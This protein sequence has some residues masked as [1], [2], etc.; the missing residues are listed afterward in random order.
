MKTMIMS[1]LVM[2][3]V[4]TSPKEIKGKVSNKVNYENIEGAKVVVNSKDTVYTDSKGYFLLENVDTLKRIDVFY[5]N[6]RP[7]DF[8]L[9]RVNQD[10]IDLYI[11]K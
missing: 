11:K 6:N 4:G 3:C 1:F 5:E 7:N 10:D 2:Y 9:V 8:S